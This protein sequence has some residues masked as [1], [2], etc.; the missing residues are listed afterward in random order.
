MKQPKAKAIWGRTRGGEWRQVVAYTDPH[1]PLVLGKAINE[2]GYCIYHVKSGGSVVTRPKLAELRPLL[3]KLLA[4]KG[5]DWGQDFG[6]LG[7]RADLAARVQLIVGGE[8]LH[9]NERAL[10]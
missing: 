8:R 10:T 6:T 2:P 1:K 7:A 5:I 3:S 9:V 4:M